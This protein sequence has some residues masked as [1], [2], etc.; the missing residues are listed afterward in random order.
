MEQTTKLRCW[1]CNEIFHIRIRESDYKT[2]STVCKIV[3]CPYCHV[4]CEV[5]LYEEQIPFVEVIRGVRGKREEAE[6][7]QIPWGQ[8]LEPGALVEHVFQSTRPEEPKE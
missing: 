6:K 3:P 7:P 1:N 4:Q 5:E 8:I 2:Y